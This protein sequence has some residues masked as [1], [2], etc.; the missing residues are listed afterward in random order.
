[1]THPES[2][3]AAGQSRNL[4]SSALSGG[5]LW[6]S[7]YLRSLSFPV[8]VV[9]AECFPCFPGYLTKLLQNHTAQACDGQQ[10]SLH[11]PRH[12][13][14]SVQSAFYGQDPRVCRAGEPGASMAEPRDCVAPTSL[15]VPHA[16]NVLKG[17][18]GCDGFPAVSV[19]VFSGWNET[20][21]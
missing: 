1:M 7:D 6:F 19:P 11:C 18:G 14:I 21:L 3:V 5:W 2:W 13:T 12:S 20:A 10:L 17:H 16:V 15:Q 4:G 8:L 9:T